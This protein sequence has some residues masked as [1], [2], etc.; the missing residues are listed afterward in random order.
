MTAYV[1]AQN[2]AGARTVRPSDDDL[3]RAAC[4]AMHVGEH[5]IFRALPS[6]LNQVIEYKIWKSRTRQFGSFGEYA[7]DQTSEGLGVTNNQ[8]LWMLRCAL[9]VHGAH[10][11]EWASVLDL[12]EKSV[13]I[14]AKAEGKK[15]SHFDGN[16][17]ETLAK[18]GT[19]QSPD[20]KITYLPSKNKNDDG[21][22]L[23]LRK[24]KALYTRVV[25]GKIGIRDALREAGVR[26]QDSDV[27][28]DPV[29]RAIMYVKRMKAVDIK[30]LV[31][32]MTAEGY[33]K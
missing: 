4:K 25:A 30:R 15:I 18:K 6:V 8:L 3:H 28:R 33:V 12:V 14:Q 29:D 20:Q 5:E 16:S 26:R 11:R 10:V 23:R 7:L 24:H 32:W 9:D 31:K 2:T 22:L 27:N 19:D 13:K 1:A 17:L 21:N